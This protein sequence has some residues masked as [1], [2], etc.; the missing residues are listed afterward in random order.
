MSDRRPSSGRLT[1]LVGIGIGLTV[2]LFRQCAGKSTPLQP[3][4]FGE[5]LER[6]KRA[7]SFRKVCMWR[8]AEKR[9]KNTER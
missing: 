6:D 9:Q 4:V 8:A 7:A 2:P 3:G 5:T 1:V